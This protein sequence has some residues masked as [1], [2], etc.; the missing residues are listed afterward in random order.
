MKSSIKY[1]YTPDEIDFLKEIIKGKI[2]PEINKLYKKKFNKEMT[3][4]ELCAFK[5]KY[6][7][8]SGVFYNTRTEPN[9]QKY[10]YTQEEMN[11]LKNI[12]W[13]N[14]FKDVIKKYNKKFNK[15]M[16]FN[17]YM[18]FRRKY[19]LKNG[20]SQKFDGANPNPNPPAPI[21]HEI[22]YY[23]KGLKRIK[24]KV[25]ENKWVEKTRYIYEQHYGKIPD[26]CFIIFLDGNRD[27]YNIE[28]LKCITT[29]Q[30]RTMAGNKLYFDNKDL[31]ETGI[32]VAKLMIKT[33]DKRK[34]YKNETNNC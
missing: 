6:G 32:A 25:G 4:N 23:N 20:I 12:F 29:K 24:V 27:N 3:Y 2:F 28:N 21:G 5:Q 8:K 10:F 30:H 34:E 9:N 31:T 7:I 26:N 17:E 11:Y 19:K 33:K 18:A 16:D 14:S 13:G 1:F 22:I 15:N